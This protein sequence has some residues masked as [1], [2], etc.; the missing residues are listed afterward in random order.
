[1]VGAV[2]DVAAGDDDDDCGGVDDVETD[3]G[4]VVDTDVVGIH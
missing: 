1:M 2:V 3:V 4:V